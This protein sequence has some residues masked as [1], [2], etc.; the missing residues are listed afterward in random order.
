MNNYQEEFGKIYDEFVD[1]IYRFVFIKVNSEE[2]AEDLTSD[3]F[4]RCYQVYKRDQ[5]SIDN[6]Q[7]FLYQIARNLIVDHYR[8][9]SKNKVVSVD[10]YPIPDPKSDIEKSVEKK[11]DMEKI[12]AV[13]AGLDNSDYQDVVVWH[14]VDDLSVPEIAKI[15]EKPEGTIRVMIHRALGEV[16]KK[17]NEI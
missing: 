13:L 14:Y 15:M 5:N 2:I 6:I 4:L 16:R 7:A 17:I 8:S 12:K 3:V 9:K 1:K 10:D 11:I